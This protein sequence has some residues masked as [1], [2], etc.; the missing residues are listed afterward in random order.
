MPN[1]KATS[2]LIGKKL[3]EIGRGLILRYYYGICLE[4]LGKTTKK[5]QSG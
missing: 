1:E 3:E 4:E 5:P 2:K